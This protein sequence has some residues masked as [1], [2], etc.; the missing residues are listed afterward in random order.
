[1][2]KVVEGNRVVCVGKMR[3]DGRRGGNGITGSEEGQRE[4]VVFFRE[5]L[6]LLLANDIENS[7][8]SPLAASVLPLS[9]E[10]LASSWDMAGTE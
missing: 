3:L 6:L 7:A 5:S 9:S 10:S 4:N 2:E 8:T 1:M